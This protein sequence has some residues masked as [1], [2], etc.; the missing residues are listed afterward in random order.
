VG[1]RFEKIID[2]GRPVPGRGKITGGVKG[3]QRI[4][5][6][7]YDTPHRTTGTRAKR[8]EALLEGGRRYVMRLISTTCRRHAKDGE[9][10]A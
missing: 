7:E 3:E 5:W 8:I 10:S 4:P 1:D 9:K 2:R 6:I